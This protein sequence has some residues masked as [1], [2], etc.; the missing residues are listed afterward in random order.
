M[1]KDDETSVKGGYYSFSDYGYE[2][3][4]GR[5]WTLDP[6]ANETPSVSPFVAYNDNPLNNQDPDGKRVKPLNNDGLMAFT[7]LL[8]SY[9][10]VRAVSQVFGMTRDRRN[11]AFYS[12]HL[13]DQVHSKRSLNRALRR[14]GV[15]LDSEQKKSA[16]ATYMAIVDAQVI[17]VEGIK[18]G[19]QSNT[20]NP[21]KAGSQYEGESSKLNTNPEL[22]KIQKDVN[23]AG[24]A[25]E[26]IVKDIFDPAPGN[27][28][29]PADQKGDKYAVYGPDMNNDS[30]IGI[31]GT[32]LINTSE[33]TS[34]GQ[35]G[36]TLDKALQKLYPE[37]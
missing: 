3:R 36:Q 20:M 28:K 18:A 37:Q 29:Y 23:N 25:T 21:G 15:R 10:D 22:L 27:E 8:A 13:G 34:N 26:K 30:N 9:G 4:I 32:I 12:T 5:R 11:G 7:T 1:E 19:E 33:P 16:Y 35:N 31:K 17:E 2:S 14:A 24:S 6:A